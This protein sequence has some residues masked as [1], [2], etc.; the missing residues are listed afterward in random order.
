MK[1]AYRSADLE[2]VASW[3]EAYRNNRT[4]RQGKEPPR[5]DSNSLRQAEHALDLARRLVQPGSVA[6]LRDRPGAGKTIV[7]LLA[8]RYLAEVHGDA[9]GR[10]QKV[11]VICPND[12]MRKKWEGEEAEW[13]FGSTLPQWLTVTTRSE[14]AL[15]MGG[16]GEGGLVVLDEAHHATHGNGKVSARLRA[17]CGSSRLLLVTATPFQLST[18]GMVNMFELNRP[19]SPTRKA[20][21]FEPLKAYGHAVSHVVRLWREGSLNLS[22]SE[23]AAKAAEN[24]RRTIKDAHACLTELG[25]DDIQR[26]IAAVP[27]PYPP[28]VVPVS[29]SWGVAYQIAK[30]LPN[31]VEGTKSNDTLQRM[32]TSSTDAFKE[33]QFWKD[34]RAGLGGLSRALEDGLNNGGLHP[35]V[36]A[37]C[38]LVEKFVN[39]GHHVLVFCY[40]VKTQDALL[41]AL[42]A[43]LQRRAE[44]V[45]PQGLADLKRA[46]SDGHSYIERFTRLAGRQKPVVIVAR[47]NLSEGIDLDGGQPAVV[48]HDLPWNP[49]RM[50]QR[51]G[52]VTRRRTG[53]VPPV[54]HVACVLGVDVDLRL[55]E[56]LKSR[57]HQVACMIPTA[58]GTPGR[59]KDDIP[60]AE[61][62]PSGDSEIAGSTSKS[63]R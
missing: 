46:S 25:P 15:R 33:S 14:E 17:Y 49:A 36:Q 60:W 34:E 47:D 2:L 20:G 1:P 12:T 50:T 42:S 28:H 7:S 26:D 16:P 43:R 40:F 31:I 48:H 55:Y 23:E 54:A 18:H 19:E 37:T 59:D 52:R 13:L 8:A 61:L 45:A 5:G 58:S 39:H 38:E 6:L 30:L 35:K 51:V 11:T 27:F 63:R 56:T 21:R 32:L 53:M 44:V 57:R 10:I 29:E 62:L 4:D 9:R 24:F 3:L 41:A 22:V